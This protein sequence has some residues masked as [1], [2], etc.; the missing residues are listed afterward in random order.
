MVL[1]SPGLG[2]SVFTDSE[3]R[4]LTVRRLPN[5]FETFPV[6]LTDKDGVVRADIPFRRAESRYSFEQAGVTAS[7][8]GGA[9]NGQTFKEPATVKKYARQ[10]QRGEAFEFDRETLNSDGVFRTSPQRLVH[11]RTRC[12]CPVVLLWSHLAWFPDT[13]PGCV[14]WC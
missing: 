7:F 11:L 1:P 8:Y 6:I 4:E 5:F 9:L 2:H 13:L 3:G 12:L 14:C 10:A